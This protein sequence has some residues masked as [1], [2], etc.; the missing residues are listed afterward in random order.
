MDGWVG[1]APAHELVGPPED[2]IVRGL[3]L[4]PELLPFGAA[5][6]PMI[7][8]AP[9]IADSQKAPAELAFGFGREEKGLHPLAEGTLEE[10]GQPGADAGGI[11]NDTGRLP[12]LG[13]V[14]DSAVELVMG[15]AGPVVAVHDQKAGKA[16]VLA[17]D[18][19]DGS[20][21]G[22][23]ARLLS[24]QESAFD[25]VLGLSGDIHQDGVFPALG[26]RPAAKMRS[27][28]EGLGGRRE[29]AALAVDFLQEV[30]GLDEGMIAPEAV[31]LASHVLF[32]GG[33]LCRDAL[34]AHQEDSLDTVTPLA[35]SQGA[36]G[37]AQKGVGRPRGTPEDGGYVR[38]GTHGAKVLVPLGLVDVLSLVGLEQDIGGGADD[39][40]R[41]GSGEEEGPGLTDADHVAPL[42]HGRREEAPLED[43]GQAQDAVEGLWP[44]GG[45]GLDQVAAAPPKE[46]EKE[47]LDVGG[48]LVL[49]RLAG[50]HDGEGEAAPMQHRID[51]GP[52]GG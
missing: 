19:H 39:V 2:L 50:H 5:I 22:V 51:D 34:P 28:H 44:E 32:V 30:L 1:H 21:S 33:N 40:G 14:N 11:D 3:Y 45:R 41:R 26:G 25:S 10:G 43:G 7:Q 17:G 16:Q 24:A 37:A 52:R 20:G 15:R 31:D 27:L 13:Q 8:E 35:P 47:G 46:I 29:E 12:Q 36:D 9:R 4:A 49:A 18:L 42:A 6:G 23:L 48:G 38:A